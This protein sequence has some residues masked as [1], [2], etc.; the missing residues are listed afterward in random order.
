MYEVPNG[1]VR[2]DYVGA[3][4]QALRQKIANYESQNQQRM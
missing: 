1:Y 4:M 2:T 3:E